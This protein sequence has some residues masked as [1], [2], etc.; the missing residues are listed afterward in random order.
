MEW[1]RQSMKD[2]DERVAWF[3]QARFGMFVHW[4]A[5]SHLG[6]VW[7]GKPVEGYAEHIMRKEKIPSAVYQ[8]KLAAPFNPT[9]FNADEWMANAKKAG[10]GY[11]I[12]TV[13]APRRLRHVRLGRSATTTWSRRRPGSTIR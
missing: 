4:G 9:E 3:R 2:R 6:G 5:Y 12:I 10:M 8:E 11:F 1:W 7:N 13:E